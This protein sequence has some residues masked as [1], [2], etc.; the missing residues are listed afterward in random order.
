MWS[1]SAGARSK[2]LRPHGRRRRRSA[3]A[4]PQSRGSDRTHSHGAEWRPALS[5]SP[6]PAAA[7]P[8]SHDWC[9][10]MDRTFASTTHQWP[11]VHCSVGKASRVGSSF[12]TA[13]RLWLR[14]SMRSTSSGRW[15]GSAPRSWSRPAWTGRWAR[16]RFPAGV[17]SSRRHRRWPSGPARCCESI[18]PRSTGS[19][20]RQT[21]RW[22]CRVAAA[23][24]AQ[25]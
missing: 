13:S 22:C 23:G 5:G 9:V 12:C 1:R 14:C 20:R 24:R 10:P 3:S 18:Y 21:G 25:R 2:R 4:L 15:P 8:A 11:Q 19:C 16:C 7:R 6:A 17:M